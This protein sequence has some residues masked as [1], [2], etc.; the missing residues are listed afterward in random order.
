MSLVGGKSNDRALAELREL[1]PDEKLERP[2]VGLNG[3]G[4]MT[5]TT[6]EALLN[7]RYAFGALIEI[8]IALWLQSNNH[9]GPGGLVGLSPSHYIG[10]GHDIR[11]SLVLAMVH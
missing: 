11:S 6:K 4:L 8:K 2:D 9:A 5:A 1:I 3:R 7:L 10:F